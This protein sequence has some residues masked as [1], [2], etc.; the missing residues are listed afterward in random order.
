MRPVALAASILLALPVAAHAHGETSHGK[1]AVNPAR[2]EQQSFGR[3]GDP[4]GGE[5]YGEDHDG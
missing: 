5:T 2:A 4:Q 1:P 3:A